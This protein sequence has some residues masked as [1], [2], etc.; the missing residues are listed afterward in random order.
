MQ[1]RRANSSS[2]R[3][4]WVC[5]C[6]SKLH[7]NGATVFSPVVCSSSVS[8]LSL[9]LYR[10]SLSWFLW[11]VSFPGL[12]GQTHRRRHSIYSRKYKK[13]WEDTCENIF[14]FIGMQILSNL[15]ALIVWFFIGK[16]LI[17]L[18]IQHM[19]YFGHFFII[20]LFKPLTLSVLPA[21]LE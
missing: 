7:I 14:S 13:P 17:W 4:L 16:S 1:R 18:L 2:K 12:H 11:R 9:H 20:K 8:H 5:G 10:P 19:K 3:H 15:V 21:K 6:A